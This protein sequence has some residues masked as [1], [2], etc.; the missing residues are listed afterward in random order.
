M[1]Y[2]LIGR[3]RNA[4]ISIK[5]HTQIYTHK[6]CIFLFLSPN[7]YTGY[8]KIKSESVKGLS[9]DWQTVGAARKGHF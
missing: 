1:N 5:T 2:P 7:V 8:T 4:Q 9:R 6:A 3:S